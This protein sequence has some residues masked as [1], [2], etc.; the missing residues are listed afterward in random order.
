MTVLYATSMLDSVRGVDFIF[1]IH[2]IDLMQNFR[3]SYQSSYR[4]TIARYYKLV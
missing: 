3:L 4:Q 2:F 1:L